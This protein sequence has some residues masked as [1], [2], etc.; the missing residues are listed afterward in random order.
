MANRRGAGLDGAG[1]R[2]HSTRPRNSS[3]RSVEST[4]TYALPGGVVHETTLGE[5][6]LAGLS[7]HVAALE[8]AARARGWRP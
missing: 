1:I 4:I 3:P 2:R 8:R 5:L 7:R 6:D